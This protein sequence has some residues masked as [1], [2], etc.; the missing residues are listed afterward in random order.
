MRNQFEN[1][2]QLYLA[3]P[4]PIQGE[5]MTRYLMFKVAIRNDDRELASDC[6]A[7]LSN[8][9]LRCHEFLY[10][11][12]LDAQSV[13]SRYFAAEAMKSLVENHNFGSASPVHLPALI[14]CTIRLLVLGLDPES[15]REVVSGEAADGI[16]RMFEAGKLDKSFNQTKGIC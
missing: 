6:L 15:G 16:C 13:G 12:I 8:P 7:T 14:R 3:M 11:C 2:K 5:P 10:A 1:A 9:G 4:E